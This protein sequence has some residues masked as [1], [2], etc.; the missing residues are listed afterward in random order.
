MRLGTK[1]LHLGVCLVVGFACWI[2]GYQHKRYNVRVQAAAQATA[3]AVAVRV[4]TAAQ[5]A[6]VAVERPKLITVQAADLADIRG[7]TLALNPALADLSGLPLAIALRD[8]MHNHIT[9]P[10]DR[11][12]SERITRFNFTALADTYRISLLDP[13]AAHACGGRTIQYLSALKAF[14]FTAR[15][16]ALYSGNE[17]LDHDFP[18]H[19]KR[20][21]HD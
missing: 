6:A 18:S 16:I 2:G 20:R 12:G 4:Q 10:R 1:T 9:F 7:L 15:L 11:K 5:A 13:R 21:R 8:M 3:A 17:K 19:A 14:G